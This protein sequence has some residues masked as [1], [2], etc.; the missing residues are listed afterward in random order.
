[1]NLIK[2]KDIILDATSG[3]NEDGVSI[4]N[5]YLRGRYVHA[6]NW[7]Y[8]LPLEEADISTVK[9]VCDDLVGK[10][11]NDI[12]NV[13]KKYHWLPLEDVQDY[14]DQ[15]TTLN[16]NDIN[17]YISYNS[18]VPSELTVGDLKKF[19]TWLASTILSFGVIQEDKIIHML[20]YYAN[21]MYDDVVKGLSDFGEDE[22]NIIKESSSSPC[23]CGSSSSQT[24]EQLQN[25]T[26]CHP[27]S[28]YRLNVYKYMT[29]VFSDM[30]WWLDFDRDFLIMFKMYIDNIIKANFSFSKASVIDDYAECTCRIDNN[31][32]QNKSIER[33]SKLSEALGMMINN[34]ISGHKNYINTALGDWSTYLYENMEW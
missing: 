8:V 28:T 19:R 7:Q 9:S 32:K 18:F 31:S 3:L 25:I 24:M 33:L 2:I 20:K 27:L 16:I 34:D 23:G 30:Y 12:T 15:T 22:Y 6:I 29:E 13:L 14:I 11:E 1:M 17:K 26:L 10:Q 5:N 21:G 4:F